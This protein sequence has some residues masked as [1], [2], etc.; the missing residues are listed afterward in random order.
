MYRTQWAGLQDVKPASGEYNTGKMGFQIL[1]VVQDGKGD[2]IDYPA[3]SASGGSG[4]SVRLS[5]N[6]LHF[7]KAKSEK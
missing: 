4:K 3:R 1:P 5:R 6:E 7:S 2:A